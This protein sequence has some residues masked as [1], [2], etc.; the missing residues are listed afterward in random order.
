[1]RVESAVKSGIAAGLLLVLGALGAVTSA[2]LAYAAPVTGVVVDRAGKP[3]EYA[4]VSVPALKR[5]AA[6]DEQGAFALEL[7]LGPAVVEA[8]QIGYE[9]A[10]VAVTVADAMAPLRIVL[11]EEPVPL[12]EV[13]VAT[14]AFG[15]AGKSEGAVV[16]R[17]DIVATPGGATDIFQALR[18]LPGINAPNDEAALFVRGGDPHETLIRLDAGEIGHPYHYESA[19]G[20]L[21]SVLDS[22]MIES[23]Y[24]SSG[25]FSARYGGVL[26][27]VLDIRTQDPMNLKTVSLGA[28]LAGQSASSTWALVP[29]KVSF[30]GSLARSAPELL[31]RLYGT[32]RDYESAPLSTNGV[33]KLIYRYSPSGRLSLA[34]L[35]SHDQVGVD[36]E[37][38][39]ARAEYSQKTGNR[40]GALQFKDVLASSVALSGQV[41]GQWYENRWGFGPIHASQTERNTQANL[42]A[43]WP[44]NA[45]HELSFG[46]NFRH[47][48]TEIVGQFAADSTDLLPG[49]PTRSHVTRPVVDYP[50]AYLEDKLRLVGP[51]YATLGAR[52]DYASSPGV[53][54]T[55]PRAALAW[56]VDG[57]QTVRLAAGRYH[58]L[59]DPRFLDP[60]YGNPRLGPL[61]ADHT[62][63]G[64][65][66]KTEDAN[67]RVE[68]Y[69][70]DYRR[71]VTNDAA[72]FYANGGSGYARGVDV[73]VQGTH[74]ALTGWV[75]YGYMDSKRKELDDPHQVRSRYG[76][77]HSVTL[78]ARCQV[79]STW[80]LGTR[81]S[82]TSGRPVTPVVGRSY[83]PGR[84]I[85]HPIYGEH[86]SDRLPDFNR[87]D[88]RVTK[89]FSLPATGA[90]PTSSVCV[91]YIEG[92]N[93]LGLRNAQDYAYNSDYSQRRPI[94]SVFS[95]R[96]LVAGFSLSW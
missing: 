59:A 74:R 87:L 54:T 5:G 78:V 44:L 20:G 17:M 96:L 63:A 29:D 16:R 22:Y 43:V 95:R 71:L 51:L 90:L 33:G 68:A 46:G 37:V 23:A 32:S 48:D 2:G 89:L 75:S 61:V 73:F 64:Y 77:G 41:A 10:R 81:Y 52:A 70:K 58:Q 14:S 76:S 67:I 11:R 82:Y 92:L 13:S 35:E 26:S 4:T 80:Q 57:H 6:T 79:R 21:F 69:R 47:H 60:L 84:A 15:K 30:V 85:W 72:S 24:F 18:A 12:A 1:M 42:D 31:F 94:D 25:G 3:V 66:W 62:I 27:G 8:T 88:V 83:D 55:D 91:F 28:N 9:R 65:E 40:F 93:V 56:R 34:Y 45:R 49:A 19:S 50:G 86:N 39:N 7:P 36:V 53:W 38:L